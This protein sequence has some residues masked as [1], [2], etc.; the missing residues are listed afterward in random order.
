MKMY[1]HVQLFS[2]PGKCYWL[3]NVEG[4]SQAKV[5]HPDFAMADVYDSADTPLLARDIA[6]T[7]SSGVELIEV[8]VEQPTEVPK[9]IRDLIGI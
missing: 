7:F 9:P 4:N 3:C 8:A 6:L 5:L 2:Q 1:A